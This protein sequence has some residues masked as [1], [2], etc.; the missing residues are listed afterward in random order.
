MA[1]S[2]FPRLVLGSLGIFSGGLLL[3]K[4]P[5]GESDILKRRHWLANTLLLLSFT[6]AELTLENLSLS[7]GPAAFNTLCVEDRM[8]FIEAHSLLI[9]ILGLSTC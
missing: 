6:N 1:S 2:L 3:K 9:G 4:L 5:G 7:T 8:D